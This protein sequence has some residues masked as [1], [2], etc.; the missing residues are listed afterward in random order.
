MNNGIGVKSIP[1]KYAQ[2]PLMMKSPSELYIIFFEAAVVNYP[3]MHLNVD[4]DKYKIK[5][6]FEYLMQSVTRL[7]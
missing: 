2:T 3:A 6:T 4:V 5:L 1:G 7:I